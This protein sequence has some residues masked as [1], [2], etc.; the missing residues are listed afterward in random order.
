[1]HAQFCA[2]QFNLLL[3]GVQKLLAVQLR[4]ILSQRLSFPMNEVGLPESAGYD[5]ILE[6]EIA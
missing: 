5:I 6:W 4:Q 1:L 2:T 3:H